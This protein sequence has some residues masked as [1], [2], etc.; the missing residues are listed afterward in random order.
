MEKT[1]EAKVDRILEFSW[2]NDQ[3][4]N[5]DIIPLVDGTF[6]L[7]HE[8]ITYHCAVL[9]IEDNHKSF[10]VMV[11]GRIMEVEIKDS[12]DLLIQK[13]GM[14]VSGRKASNDIIAPMPGMILKVLVEE[15]QV[16]NVGDEILV[17]EAMKME[18]VIKSPSAAK[19]NKIDVAQGASVEKGQVLVYLEAL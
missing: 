3:I 15:G 12:L 19:V 14:K 1:Y 16:V 10:S 4:R 5:L 9:D 18:N 13:M 7:I 2:T 11:N 17:L 6:H 8:G